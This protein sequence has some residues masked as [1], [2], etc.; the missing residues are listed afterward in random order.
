MKLSPLL[1]L[2]AASLVGCAKAPTAPRAPVVVTVYNNLK[3][4]VSL[5]VGSVPYGA[6]GPA[7]QVVLTL[8][9]GTRAISF[10]AQQQRLQSGSYAYLA[11]DAMAYSLP[12]IG[13]APSVQITNVVDGQAYFSLLIYN[14]SGAAYS[15]SVFDGGANRCILG[16]NDT[17]PLVIYRLGYFKL[18]PTVVIRAYSTNNCT[19]DRY[20]FWSNV[21]LGRFEPQPG[22]M[23][24][25]IQ[26]F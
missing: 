12:L 7:R 22:D 2:S 11:D 26:R 18:T 10:A 8:P 21:V 24:I 6:L 1:I 3:V 23:P 20:L 16:V 17:S 15:I 19:G 5:S 4:E 13:T 25:N 9:P 14:Q